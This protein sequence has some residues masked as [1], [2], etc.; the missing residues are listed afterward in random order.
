MNDGSVWCWGVSDAFTT[1]LG[2]LPTNG[3]DATAVPQMK[4]AIEISVG[5]DTICWRNAN[6]VS[7]AGN[8]DFG[9]LGVGDKLSH[10]VVQVTFPQSTVAQL[11][12]GHATMCALMVDSTVYCWG[13][14]ASG[15]ADPMTEG[16]DVVR[17]TAIALS[18]FGTPIE[19]RTGYSYACARMMD[20]SVVCW[21]DNTY[22]KVGHVPPDMAGYGPTR[23]TRASD[24]MQLGGALGLGLGGD[25][26]CAIVANGQVACWGNDDQAQLGLG[27]DSGVA[28]SARATIVS[29][30]T[31]VSR[32]VAGDGFSCA[33]LMNGQV[34]CWGAN[35]N[36]QCGAD[37]GTVTTQ[38]VP[39]QVF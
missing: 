7:C 14:N 17:P 25:H 27:A 22:G 37:P 3:V 8:N 1:L 10:G 19:V 6:G 31:G 13:E 29:T 4:D 20:Q 32:V 12:A 30:L 2:T 36:A 26:L 15:A 18:T 23:I 21:G 5:G 11:A 24:M 16:T 33:L 35:G 38:P 39:R 34:W 28:P 9:Q